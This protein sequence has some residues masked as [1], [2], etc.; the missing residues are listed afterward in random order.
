MK[1]YNVDR[2]AD[3]SGSALEVSHGSKVWVGNWI[4]G[5]SCCILTKNL[6]IFYLCL[7]N[8]SEAEFKGKDLVYLVNKT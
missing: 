7:A 5:H 1:S 4:R 8:Q 3:S 6:A 2:N